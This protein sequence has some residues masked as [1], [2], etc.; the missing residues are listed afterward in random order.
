MGDI[1]IKSE[2]ELMRFLKIVA[3]ESYNKTLN[4]GYSNHENLYAADEKRYGKLSEVEEDEED[5]FGEEE[6]TPAVS[7]EPAKKPKPREKEVELTVSFDSVIDRLNNLRSGRS[8]R[9]KEIK[10]SLQNYYDKLDD[11]ERIVLKIFLEEI[12]EILGGTVDG[13][14]ALDPSDPPGNFT[15]SSGGESADK[16]AK[17]AVERE[18]PAEKQPDL[19]DDNEDEDTSPPE[20]LPVTPG[21][22]N[23]KRSD[24]ELRMKVRELMER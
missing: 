15:I 3:Q 17:D 12:S 7:Q 10:S 6:S 4:E 8:T 5:L 20:E 22:I 9:D 23:E 19:F 18:A 14:N 24:R 21:G 11:N 1:N 2:K 16:D 13:A